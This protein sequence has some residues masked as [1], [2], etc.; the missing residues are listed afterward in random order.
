MI[1]IATS[2]GPIRDW[3]RPQQVEQQLAAARQRL[4]TSPAPIGNYTLGFCH[5]NY[6][7]PASAYLSYMAWSDSWVLDKLKQLPFPVEVV[8][9]SG[10]R[11][12]PP[13]WSQRVSEAGLPLTIIEEASHNFTGPQEFDFQESLLQLLE[14][15]Q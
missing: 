13:D 7:A 8:L 6:A 2:I 4:E 9:G 15:H 1:F 3:K 5:D 12:L 10:D 14:R 11:W